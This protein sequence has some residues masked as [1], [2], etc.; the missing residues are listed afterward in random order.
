MYFISAFYFS[1]LVLEVNNQS[2]AITG[3]KQMCSPEESANQFHMFPLIRSHIKRASW[4][5]LK[6]FC[7]ILTFYHNIWK[8]YLCRKPKLNLFSYSDL[9]WCLSSFHVC[10]LWRNTSLSMDCMLSMGGFAEVPLFNLFW[11]GIKRLLRRN[12]APKWEENIV[13][14]RK[15]GKSSK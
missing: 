12:V 3:R 4:S 1:Y 5:L 6:N 2:T 14:E 8:P 15:R 10:L 13:L 11:I 7:P 9:L